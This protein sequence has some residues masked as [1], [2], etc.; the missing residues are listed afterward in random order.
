MYQHTVTLFNR[1]VAN[2]AEKWKGTVLKGVDLIVDRAAIIARYG[3][4]C[5]DRAKLHIKKSADGMI[6]GF[7]Y[8][9][10]EDFSGAAGTL[11][12]AVGNEFS[13]FVDG[14]ASILSASEADY[15]EPEEDEDEAETL[16]ETSVDYYDGFFDYMNRTGNAYAITSV[17]EY[18]VIPHWEI[19]GR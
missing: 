9:A 17:A 1:Y 16:V 13:F 3:A 5:Q 7:R 11:T 12:F 15:S 8:V 19:S 6:N 4:D 18:Y 14:V 2:G 10:P